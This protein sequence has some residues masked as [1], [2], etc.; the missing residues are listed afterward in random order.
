MFSKAFH[1]KGLWYYPK[2]KK[3]PN[4]TIVG[5]S[6]F[7]YRSVYRDIEAQLVIYSDNQQLQEQLHSVSSF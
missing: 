7:G 2:N 3:S 6:N 4:M 1:G 5:S